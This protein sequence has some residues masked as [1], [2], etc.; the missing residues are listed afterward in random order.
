MVVAAARSHLD[1]RRWEDALD[2]L[3]AVPAGGGPAAHVATE[4]G[5][6]RA[7]ALMELR[8]RGVFGRL[9]RQ[10]ADGDADGARDSLRV[11]PEDSVYRPQAEALG[12]T[13]AR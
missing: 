1:A 11:L 12:K 13:L 8:N 7:R 4:A 2:V 6:L 5:E 9:Q 10:V 3:Q